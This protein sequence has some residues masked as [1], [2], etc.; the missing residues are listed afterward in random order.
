MKISYSAPGKIILCG[1]H[2]VVYGKPALVTAIDLK[3]T[4][5]LSS[6]QNNSSLPPEIAAIKSAT[7]E[8]LKKNK[9]SFQEK[10]FEYS[11]TSEIP[12]GRGMGS[13]AALCVAGSAAMLEYFTGQ[14]IAK[15]VINSVAYQAEK[16]FHKNPSGV[17]VSAACYGG[18][19]YFRKEFEFLKQ[20][21]SLNFKIP[22]K[23]QEKLLLIDTGESQESTK[24]MVEMVGK[25]YNDNPKKI[26]AIFNDIE[27]VTK[28]M[29]IAIA[30][31][32]EKMFAECI[33]ENG[34]L[35]QKLGTVSEKTKKLLK[36]LQ[37]YGVGEVPG[38]GGIK[39]G[40]GFI[41]FMT[42]DIEKTKEFLQKYKCLNFIQ[43]NLGVSDLSL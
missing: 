27:R 22:K 37:P 30:G 8:Y 14:K 33:E 43:S 2:A 29:V 31:E 11:I 21:S 1:V 12:V 24:E 40:S 20:I 25:K 38:A 17:D 26:A 4:F 16:Y 5:E 10:P 41:L 42:K 9:I 6:T 36:K 34:I 23:I 13:S 32:N 18:L 19:I 15:E 7:V 39:D 35:L 28:R 3:L